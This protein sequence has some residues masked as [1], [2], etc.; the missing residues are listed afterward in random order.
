MIQQTSFPK[1]MTML[2]HSLLERLVARAGSRPM[3]RANPRPVTLR[4]TVEALEHR[5][6]PATA[7][8]SIADATIVEGN[9]GTQNALVTV[10]LNRPH[11]KVTVNYSTADGSA[12]AGSDYT[13]VS[14]RLTFAKNEMSKTIA[15]PVRGDRLV[16][17]DEYFSVN[18]SNASGAKIGDGT[19]VVTIIDN[20]PRAYVSNATVVEGNDGTSPAAFTVTLSNVYDRPVTVN[21]STADGSATAGSDYMATSGSVTIPAGQLQSP[22]IVVPVRGDRLGELTETFSLL[23]NTT[24]NYAQMGNATAVGTIID[25]EPQ[26]SISDTYNYGEATMTF[27]VTLSAPYD[28][29]VTVHYATLDGTAIAGVDYVADSGTLTFDAALGET[30]KTITIAVL[31]PTSVPDKYFQVQLSSASTNAAIGNSMATGNWYYDYGY[32]YGG[33]YDY[34]YGYYDYGYGW[35]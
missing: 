15:V 11:G 7:R 9:D 25:N 33:G 10:S 35:Y 30:T 2:F 12:T 22:D 23:V 1:E 28:Q 20:E 34:G 3:T 17:F 16:E 13:A 4:P 32:Y 5:L 8:L 27:T 31:D 6:T 18:L 24:D 14:G 21:Y 26:I 29:N 19:G